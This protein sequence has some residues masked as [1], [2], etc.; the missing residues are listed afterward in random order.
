MF[1][2][3][4]TFWTA[5]IRKREGALAKLNSARENFERK[6][7]ALRA[8]LREASKIWAELN[9]RFEWWQSLP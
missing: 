1:Q 7:K 3:N 4:D 5:L 9:E 8:D 6:E 2:R